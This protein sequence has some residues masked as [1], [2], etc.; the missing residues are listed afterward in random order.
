MKHLLVA[1]AAICLSVASYAGDTTAAQK[2]TLQEVKEVITPGDSAQS[3]MR[4]IYNDAK[5]GIQGLA[6]ALKVGAEHVYLVLVKQQLVYSICWLI[7]WILIIIVLTYFIKFAKHVWKEDDEGGLVVSFVIGICLIV[8]LSINLCHIDNMVTG[9][10]NPEYGAIMEIM[11][12]AT[13][14]KVGN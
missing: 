6:S 14:H 2:S 5:A 13:G 11:N 10:V 3:L 9:F 4:T 1:I 12:F 8:W 7:S